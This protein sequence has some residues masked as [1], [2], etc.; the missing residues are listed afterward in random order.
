MHGVLSR[1]LHIVPIK[2]TLPRQNAGAKI[3]SA[4]KC[5]FQG[6]RDPTWGSSPTVVKAHVQGSEMIARS[7]RTLNIALTRHRSLD[8]GSGIS[9]RTLLRT[10][11]PLSLFPGRVRYQASGNLQG[12]EVS[13]C[14]SGCQANCHPGSGNRWRRL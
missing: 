4:R 5:A 3:S 9:S 10:V 13:C 12:G 7:G 1:Y 11:R 14:L 8:N 2:S 6:E